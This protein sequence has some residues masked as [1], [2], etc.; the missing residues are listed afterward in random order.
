MLKT[1]VDLVQL[2]VRLH[3]I[4]HINLVY[5]VGTQLHSL[6]VMLDVVNVLLTQLH[7]LVQYSKIHVK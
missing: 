4:V 7:V 3:L 1:H 5:Q 2:H 6:E